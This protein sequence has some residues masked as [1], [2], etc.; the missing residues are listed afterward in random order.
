MG[1]KAELTRFPILFLFSPCDV[2]A[3]EVRPNLVLAND[4]L[5]PLLVLSVKDHV[6]RALVPVVNQT[7]IRWLT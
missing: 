5:V 4:V 6:K 2:G 3:L 7:V 1:N